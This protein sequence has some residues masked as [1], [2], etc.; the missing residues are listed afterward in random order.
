MVNKASYILTSLVILV[1]CFLESKC[2]VTIR[3]LPDI[4]NRFVNVPNSSSYRE[5]DYFI[6]TDL[7]QMFVADQREGKR[8]A[9]ATCINCD[10]YEKK[11]VLQFFT[12][13]TFDSTFFE[14]DC[15]MIE[16]VY[17]R[18]FALIAKDKQSIS[19]KVSI[20]N[21]QSYVCY[22]DVD[23]LKSIKTQEGRELNFVQIDTSDLL[24]AVI[25]AIGAQLI[26]PNKYIVT[27]GRY[28]KK[29]SDSKLLFAWDIKVPYQKNGSKSIEWGNFLVHAI[30]DENLKFRIVRY[31]KLDESNL[32]LSKLIYNVFDSIQYTARGHT[33]LTYNPNDL[34]YLEKL[35][36]KEEEERL[37]PKEVTEGFEQPEFEPRVIGREKVTLIQKVIC[38]GDSFII[39]TDTIDVKFRVSNLFSYRDELYEFDYSSAEEG[40]PSLLKL[41]NILLGIYDSIHPSYYQTTPSRCW[42][43]WKFLNLPIANSDSVMYDSKSNQ[44]FP[45][46][47]LDFVLADGMKC[48][49]FR[50]ESFIP[51]FPVDFFFTKDGSLHVLAE[52]RFFERNFGS[53][54]VDIE[55]AYNIDYAYLFQGPKVY[56]TNESIAK[57]GP[58]SLT[59]QLISYLNYIEIPRLSELDSKK[60]AR[61]N[62]CDVSG[63]KLNKNYFNAIL[64]DRD[65][66][67]GNLEVGIYTSDELRSR[68]PKGSLKKGKEVYILIYGYVFK[69]DNRSKRLWLGDG[70]E[71]KAVENLRAAVDIAI[72]S[73]LCLNYNVELERPICYE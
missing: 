44:D 59:N 41:G 38:S 56:L 1:F 43:N 34:A 52:S 60:Y 29:I 21:D 58:D 65:E 45:V 7:D 72:R 10:E 64:M 2:Q 14:S 4:G 17:K 36:K 39:Q 5:S 71:L 73:V 63:L 16:G 57:F 23:S 30:L 27:R 22:A 26:K 18:S 70:T 8:P 46:T 51:M 24:M 35:K 37:V 66:V 28:L 3:S 12:L 67:L 42:K 40:K 48:D 55:Y 32:H 69:F 20:G 61:T 47:S 54:T 11:R 50:L 62:R 49:T 31:L 25:N 19:L 6:D 33:I 68:K 13:P 53:N 9:F 15:S